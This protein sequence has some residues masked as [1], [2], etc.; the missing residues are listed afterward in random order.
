M[1][2]LPETVPLPLSAQELRFV[3]AYSEC[4]DVAKSA[5][6]AGYPSKAGT[7]LYRRKAVHEEIQRRMDTINGE[8]AKL[9]AKKRI[10]NV[11]AL[12]RNLMRV[13]TIPVKVLRETPT[14]AASKVRAIE[15]GYQRTGMLLDGNFVPDGSSGPSKEQAPRIY[16]PVEQT[17]ITHQIETR[18]VVTQRGGQPYSPQVPQAAVKNPPTIDA[19]PDSW[20]NF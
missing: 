7:G 11:D 20:E 2:A 15:L 9:I 5:V 13:V 16:R 6:S 3:D 4:R 17:I 12:D 10:V 19:E 18:Q 1:E 14:L 8:T